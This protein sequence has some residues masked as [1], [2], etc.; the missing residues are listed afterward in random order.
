MLIRFGVKTNNVKN[1]FIDTGHGNIGAWFMQPDCDRDQQPKNSSKEAKP[2][3]NEDKAVL[4]VH[5]VK[6]NRAGPNRVG[7][8]N[9]LLGLGYK[10]ENIGLLVLIVN[11]LSLF[12][13]IQILC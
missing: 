12:Y 1:F 5:G 6:G 9:V 2:N 8:Y 3:P 4:Y 13:F 11:L 10:V 7:L